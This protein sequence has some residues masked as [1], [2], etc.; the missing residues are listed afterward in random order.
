MFSFSGH[1]L[2]DLVLPHHQSSLLGVWNLANLC[3]ST[4]TGKDF[5]LTYYPG[6]DFALNFSPW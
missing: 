1:P 2:R 6:K 5:V 4:H 3:W